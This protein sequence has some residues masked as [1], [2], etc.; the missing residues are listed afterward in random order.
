[1]TLYRDFTSQEEIDRQYN[2][3]SLEP[4]MRPYVELF[5]G[6]SEKARRELECVLDVRVGPTVDETVDV[7]PAKQPGAPIL[8]FI[9]GGWWR[10][11]HRSGRETRNSGR[12]TLPPAMV[13]RNANGSGP[14]AR[15]G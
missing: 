12:P 9:H 1:M 7:F 5:V 13:T 15:S 4:D 14:W 3:E 6:G 2:V 11:S 8:V 10:S